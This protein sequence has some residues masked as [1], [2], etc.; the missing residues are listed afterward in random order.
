MSNYKL[1]LSVLVVIYTKDLQILLL[2]RRD[3]PD[4]WQS[5]TGSSHP[6]ESLEQTAVREVAEE[7]GLDAKR[8]LFTDWRTNNDYEIYS[9]WRYRYAPGV[10]TNTEHVFGLELPE[11][12]PITIN[13][14]EHIGFIWL[15][16]QQAAA[17]VFSPSNK[18]AI[19]T[20]A[21]HHSVD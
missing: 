16:K 11:I 15:P 13:P 6:E 18:T 12:C 20:L 17:K 4:Y 1:P 19:E 14:R 5:V 9:E 2:E 10:T 7:T 21:Q 8:Y 3:H